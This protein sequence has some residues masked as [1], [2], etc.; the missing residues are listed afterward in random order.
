M[1]Y[2]GNS[3]GMEGSAVSLS[4][5]TQPIEVP[6]TIPTLVKVRVNS[7]LDAEV[8]YHHEYLSSNSVAPG[9]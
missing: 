3:L 5:I 1:Y 7:T 9:S 4:T 2:T 8:Y 6:L